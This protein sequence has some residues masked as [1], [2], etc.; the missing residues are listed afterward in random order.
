MIK[1]ILVGLAGTP[2]TPVAIE[3]AIGLA[4]AHDRAVQTECARQLSRC[5]LLL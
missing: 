3:R 1:R 4:K 2:Y 5:I